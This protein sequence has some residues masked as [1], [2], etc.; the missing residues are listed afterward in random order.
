MQKDY[1]EWKKTLWRALR[2]FVSAAVAT[3]GL[4]LVAIKP[5]D[6]EDWN[7]IKTFLVPVGIGAL[8]AGIV[9]FGKVLRD[10]FPDSEFVN[11]LPI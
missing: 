1:E 3:A 5:E 6:L 7:S 2:S 11:K 10:A 9:A 4:L 8:A